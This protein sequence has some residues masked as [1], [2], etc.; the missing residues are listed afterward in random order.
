MLTYFQAPVES[1]GEKSDEGFQ[2]W[3]DKHISSIWQFQSNAVQSHVANMEIY[4][5]SVRLRGTDGLLLSAC[6]KD[7]D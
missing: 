3:Q 6:T 5:A 1:L 2:F 7:D 4:M